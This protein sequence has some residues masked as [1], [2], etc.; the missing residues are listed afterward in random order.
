V[1]YFFEIDD[2]VVWS[3]DTAD[4]RLF[5]LFADQIAAALGTPHGLTR[6]AGDY[7]IVDRAGYEAFLGRV[8]ET[9]VDG[10]APGHEVVRQFVAASVVILRGSLWFRGPV[11]SICGSGGPSTSS[12]SMIV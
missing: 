11:Q 4:G 9:F 1:S 12:A 10:P 2:R 7:Y 3:P 6:W 5:L 8:A